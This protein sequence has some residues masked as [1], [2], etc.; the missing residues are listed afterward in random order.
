MK[1]YNIFIISIIILFLLGFSTTKSDP[2]KKLRA[3]TEL[4]RLVEE[5]YVDE[6]D[7]NKAL[8]GAFVGLLNELDPHSNF[9]PIEDIKEIDELF[10]GDF[11][12]IGIEFS[13]IDGYI[14]VIS[15][16]PDT[17]SSRAGLQPGDKITKI[18]GESAYQITQNLMFS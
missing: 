4:I 18:D 5:N 3:F 14:T 16:I 7:I 9:I 15:P 1:K 6:V 11:E 13:I 10:R 8:N 2:F 12:G 17:P